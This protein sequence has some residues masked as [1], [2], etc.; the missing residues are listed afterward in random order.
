M[1]RRG[2]T[3]HAGL[4]GKRGA[5]KAHVRLEFAHRGARSRLDGVTESCTQQRQAMGDIA[6][7]TKRRGIAP[8]ALKE[9]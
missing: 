3:G 8:A 5:R 1:P 6:A 7:Q 4:S 9:R 2:K